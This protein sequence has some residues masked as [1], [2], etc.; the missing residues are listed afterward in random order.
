MPSV[1]IDAD[2]Y[3]DFL[4]YTRFRDWSVKQMFRFHGVLYKWRHRTDIYALE[5]FHTAEFLLAFLAVGL[6]YKSEP[7]LLAFAGFMFH[8]TLD[9][10]RMNQWKRISARA[11][12]FVEYIVCRKKMI[13]RGFNPESTFNAAYELVKSRE[14][15]A[16]PSPETPRTEIEKL[17]ISSTL[18]A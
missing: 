12:S 10:Y 13:Q 9:L 7:L 16:N 18:P 2:H 14:I 8:M 11:L 3:L 6:Y 17:S 4:Y 5:A 1:L 15:P